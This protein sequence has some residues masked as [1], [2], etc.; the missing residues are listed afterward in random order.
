MEHTMT[1]PYLL[2]SLALQRQLAAVCECQRRALRRNQTLRQQSLRLEAHMAASGWEMLHNMEAWYGREIKRLLSLQEGNLSAGGDKEEGS[3][4]QVLQAGRWAGI[5][6]KTAVPREQ[7]HPAAAFL[8]CP[9]PAVP[10]TGGLG[11]Q[12]GPPQPPVPVG[13]GAESQSAGGES[14]GSVEGA[15][16]H[17]D[18]AARE[19]GS[20]QLISSAPDPKP[21]TPREGQW[22]GSAPGSKPGLSDWQTGTEESSAQLLVPTSA[23]EEVTRSAPGAQDRDAQA[24]GGSPLAPLS[25]PMAQEEP[26]DS[27]APDRKHT[28]FNLFDMK[29]Q[30]RDKHDNDAHRSPLLIFPT[31]AEVTSGFLELPLR[32]FLKEKVGIKDRVCVDPLVSPV[33]ATRVGV[34]LTVLCLFLRDTC[35]GHRVLPLEQ[36]RAQPPQGV[37]EV[38]DNLLASGEEAQDSQA[39]PELRENLPGEPGDRSP[40]QG[41]ESSCSFSSAPAEGREGEQAGHTA[42]DS[43]EPGVTSSCE[44]QSEEESTEEKIPI[45]GRDLGDDH[46]KANDSQDMHSESSSSSDGVVLPFSRNETQKERVTAIKSKAFWGESEDS[47]SELEAALRPQTHSAGSGDFD[48]F[49]D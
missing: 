40:V 4:E 43:G 21:A 47:S 38:S 36:P 10:A 23:E 48:D 19:E 45:T 3:S 22:Q 27:S 33:S 39:L 7:H 20:R 24:G 28:D 11:M 17:S 46:S 35:L 1:D 2:Q 6:T 37:A 32:A 26:S 42:R 44:D 18:L 12:Q 41:E 9:M 8:G 5:G 13:L 15:V 29:A 31:L 14:A 16:A 30:D 34:P 49:Y 25:P